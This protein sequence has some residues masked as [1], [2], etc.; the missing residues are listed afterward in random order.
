MKRI[1]VICLI[2][3]VAICAAAPAFAW[4]FA[5]KGDWEWRYRYWTRIGSNDIFGYMD[6]TNVNLGLN[7]IYNFPTAATTNR[8]AANYGIL[9]G[10]NNY[11]P[12]MTLTDTRATIFPKIKANNA[13]DIEASVNLTS[14]GIWSGGDPYNIAGTGT[15]GT[16]RNVGFYNSMYVPINDDPAAINVPNTFVTLQWLKATIQSPMLEFSLGYKTSAIGMG[17]W[18][19]PNSRASASFA[20]AAYYGPFKISLVPYFSRNQSAWILN[21]IAGSTATSR[22]TGASSSQRQADRRNY[23]DAIEGDIV[24]RSGDVEIQLQSDSYRQPS[25]PA[26]NGQDPVAPG[27]IATPFHG[28]AINIQ[29]RP[30]E[31]EIRYRIA[32]AMKYNNG[33]FFFNGEADWFNRWRSGRGVADPATDPPATPYLVRNGRNDAAWLYGAELG[34]LCGP[35][36]ITLNYVR[37]TGEDPS[38]RFTNEDA[39]QAEQSLS[40]S[41]MKQWAYLMSYMYGAGDGWDA[42]G[43]GQPTN[44][45]HVGGRLDYAIAA[46]LNLFAVYAQAW[47]DQPN[48]YRLGGD[49]KIG[50][51]L[52]TND[53]VLKAQTGT[54]AGH[55]VPA[56]ANDIGYEVDFGA[57]WKLLEGLTWSTTCGLW[58]PGNWWAYAFPNT[59]YLYSGVYQGGTLS[60]ITTTAGN[61]TNATF[62]L[63]REID[64]LFA[65]ETTVLISF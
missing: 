45:Q 22:N 56:S 31:D 40:A 36:K 43:Y 51:Q 53:D 55:C 57:N 34:A 46:N 8:M 49:Y 29:S 61:E 10:Q 20:V 35:S 44:I 16:Y 52:W 30:S 14:L 59:A 38:T 47:R 26:I 58:K 64:A 7:H 32:L 42:A 2:A 9:S 65:M 33:R 48:N 3:L 27:T 11:G 63:G 23:F 24:Y 39:A 41:Y 13:I 19:H 25:A 50:G 5:M 21:P 37:A 4:E 1:G 28:G 54:F 12:E 6:G 18:K 15:Q 60:G 62:N 17:L